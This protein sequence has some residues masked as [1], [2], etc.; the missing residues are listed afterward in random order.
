MRNTIVFIL[1]LS[2]VLGAF[3]ITKTTVNNP[4]NT[5]LNLNWT[6]KELG[7]RNDIKPGTIK[8]QLC[9]RLGIQ[10]ELYGS[11]RLSELN[12]WED[13]LRAVVS[14]FKIGALPRFF[15]LKIIIW[16]IGLGLIF[17]YVLTARNKSRIDKTRVVIMAAVFIGFGFIAGPSPNPMESTVQLVKHFAGIETKY[18]YMVFLFL[19]FAVLSLIG[20]K[21][22]CSWGCPLGALQESIFNIPILK[23]KRLRIPFAW[24]ITS[25]VILFVMFLLG[26]LVFA[27]YFNGR[28]IFRSVNYFN[29]FDPSRLSTVA[30]YTLPLLLILSFFI[31]RP[32]CHWICP[33]G[34]LSWIFEKV[35]VARVRVER[36]LCIDCKLC[37]KVCPTDAMR[38]IL[39]NQKKVFQADCWSCGKCISS[40]SQ[41]AVIFK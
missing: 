8:K 3:F 19:I 22:F 41:D 30:L 17:R 6:I 33:F 40:C 10:K 29:I 36:K 20:P 21:F 23:K 28:S 5:Q 27:D 26:L 32:F 35:S 15:L 13:Q 34:L 39:G 9:D 25:R 38:G 11:T 16:A 1:I 31:F 14:P 4:A 37:V 12:I 7:D 24:G 2:V 18:Q